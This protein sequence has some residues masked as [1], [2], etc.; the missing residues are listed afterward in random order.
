[1]LDLEA[2]LAAGGL[3]LPDV[4]GA[5]HDIG[6]TGADPVL[7]TAFPVGEAAAAALMAGGVAAARLH[8]LRGGPAQTVGVDVAAAAASLL[9][10][11]LQSQPA[12]GA[13][14]QLDRLNPP[15]T[16]FFQCGD[17]RWIHLHGGFPHLNDGILEL[18]GCA[19]T[20]EAVE[21]AVTGWDARQLEDALAER[22]L[23]GA[24]LR[25]YDEW[26]D[27]PQGAALGALAAVE[28]DRIGD[29]PAT[30]WRPAARPLSDIRVLDVTRVLAGPASGRT[31]ASYGADVLRIASPHLPFVQPFVV[32]T[33]H[34]KRSAFLDLRDRDQAQRFREL[35]GEADVFTD[36]YRNGSLARH[37]F[38]PES[39]AELR[40]GI[41]AVSI[42]CYGEVGPWTERAGWEQLAQT[43]S[44]LAHAHS[45]PGSPALIPAAATDYTTGYLAAWGTMEALYRRATEGGSWRV[46]VSLCQTAQWLL[47]LGPRC[48]PGEHTGFGDVRRLQTKSATPYGELR[49]LAPAVQMSVTPPRWEQPTVPLGHDAPE[50][51]PVRGTAAR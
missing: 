33:G 3:A 38:D 29:A 13:P 41:V 25:T 21:A 32:D 48:D 11:L 28:I 43:T 17:G 9:G 47:R 42:S 19:N 23:C 5:V 20:Q 7:E 31:L 8:R 16:A 6:V 46:R 27:H 50:W 40:P 10:F 1:V 34:G 22:R 26:A 2:T 4:A 45:D 49:H 12:G 30:G 35:A 44:G 24:V 15:T 14:V 51:R 39:L 37:G 18:L 36:G